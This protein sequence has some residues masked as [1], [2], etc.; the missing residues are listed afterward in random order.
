[1]NSRDIPVVTG[2]IIMT[3]MF[4]CLVLLAV[5]LLYAVVDPR[6]KAQYSGGKGKKKDGKK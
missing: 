1:M 6:I 5:D 3:T 2:S 4:L